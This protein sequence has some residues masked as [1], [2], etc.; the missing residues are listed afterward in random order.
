VHNRL[1]Q[2][3]GIIFFIIVTSPQLIALPDEVFSIDKVKLAM[4]NT[5]SIKGKF[6][7]EKHLAEVPFP[8]KSSGTFRI[9]QSNFLQWDVISPI[10]S[11]LLLNI[12]DGSFVLDGKPLD[13]KMAE[14]SPMKLIC[15]ILIAVFTGDWDTLNTY[16]YSNGKIT[17][18]N[19]WSVKL[20][21]RDNMLSG[22]IK[23]IELDGNKFIDSISIAETSGDETRLLFLHVEPIE[24]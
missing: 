7:Q 3:L 1:L 8:I 22:A 6:E 17:E 4:N 11:Q 20:T 5:A 24:K 14:A 18:S 12:K 13:G 2:K 10:T 21:P 9:E 19:D 15:E 23:V 16:F